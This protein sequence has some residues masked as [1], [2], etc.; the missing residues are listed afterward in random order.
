MG[1]LDVILSSAFAWT[2]HALTH[3]HK[4]R[5]VF[6]NQHLLSPKHATSW[7]WEMT[8]SLSCLLQLAQR[9][10]RGRKTSSYCQTTKCTTSNVP[11]PQGLETPSISEPDALTTEPGRPNQILLLIVSA[12]CT[13]A[14]PHVKTHYVTCRDLARWIFQLKNSLKII[15][16][17]NSEIKWRIKASESCFFGPWTFTVLIN[18]SL[19]RLS[20]H[21]CCLI[22]LKCPFEPSKVVF[23]TLIHLT[24]LV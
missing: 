2:T 7:T 15:S 20:A 1:L 17:F 6:C 8:L 19:S 4:H 3:T 9:T 12:V 5:Q 22:S 10:F 16:A 14:E 11:S 18:D 24:S 13:D 21:S 23:H